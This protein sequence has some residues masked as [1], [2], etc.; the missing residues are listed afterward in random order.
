MIRRPP[1]STLFPYTTLFRSPKRV[2]AKP[3]KIIR[4][5]PVAP[6]EA[7]IAPLAGGS[8]TVEPA[9]LSQP[10]Y[11]RRKRKLAI[12]DHRSAQLVLPQ[13]VDRGRD[14]LPGPALVVRAPAAPVGP[15]NG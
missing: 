5:E 1:R 11:R 6:V 7:E 4:L 3:V 14:V 8:E 12:T 2:K 10:A 15:L 13:V 9:P